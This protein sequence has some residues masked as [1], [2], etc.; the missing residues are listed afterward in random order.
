MIISLQ[1]LVKMTTRTATVGKEVE[2]VIVILA[3]LY[4]IVKNHVIIAKMVS[5]YQHVIFAGYMLFV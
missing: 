2:L 5:I 3:M 1:I 4:V